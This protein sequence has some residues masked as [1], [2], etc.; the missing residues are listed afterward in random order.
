MKAKAATAAPARCSAPVADST[1]SG[2]ARSCATTISLRCLRRQPA[3][4]E[5]TRTL[6]RLRGCV[7]LR[8]VG[9]AG[10]GGVFELPD[11]VS[12]RIG[13]NSTSVSK[14]ANNAAD[15]QQ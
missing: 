1:K 4:Q 7:D 8:P 2:S 9:D 11:N 15:P 14:T 13:A 10:G 12:K 3:V 5:R 6:S